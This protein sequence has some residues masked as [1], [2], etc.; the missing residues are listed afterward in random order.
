M[1]QVSFLIPSLMISLL[2][3]PS[4]S[5]SQ[6]LPNSSGVNPARDKTSQSNVACGAKGLGVDYVTGHCVSGQGRQV[7]PYN[8]YPPLAVPLPKP[9]DVIMRCG[10]QGRTTD[11]V[12][13]PCI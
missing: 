2:F 11:L 13:G 6:N 12:V 9:S 5:L 7:N 4:V 8:L 3:L 1:R 10:A